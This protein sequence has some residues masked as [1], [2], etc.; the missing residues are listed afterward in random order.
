MH[1]RTVLMEWDS[2]YPVKLA[3]S[4]EA[5]PSCTESLLSGV[6]ARLGAY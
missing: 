6:A 5:D 4:Q 2:I 3:H 1:F